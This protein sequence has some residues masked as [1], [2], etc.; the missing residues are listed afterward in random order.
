M[1]ELLNEVE[2]VS[3]ANRAIGMLEG[4][5]KQT[6]ALVT[7]FQAKLDGVSNVATD[8]DKGA[9]EAPEEEWPSYFNTLR[10]INCDLVDLLDRLTNLLH[11][12][13]L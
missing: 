7:R 10:I 12:C 6:E 2:H 11:R 5:V 8:L 1:K 9:I 13:E 4:T 3:I